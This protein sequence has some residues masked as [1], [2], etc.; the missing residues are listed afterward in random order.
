[1]GT[2]RSEPIRV[3]LERGKKLT[4]AVALDWPGWARS[5]KGD[6]AALETLEAYASRFAPVA[7]AAG[8]PLPEV[9]RLTVVEEVAGSGTTDF[10]APGTA[11]A[12]DAEPMAEAEADRAVALL[13]AA[14]AY[15][16][17]VVAAAP[18]EL[19]KGPR[20]G[21]RDRDKIVEHVVGA[22]IEYARKLGLPR[23]KVAAGDSAA[24][25]VLRGEIVAGLLALAASPRPGLWPPR[26]GGRR[27]AWHA[28]DHAWEM[29]DRR[30]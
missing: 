16:A 27:I 4:F 24:V 11:F 1:M 21:G 20:G 25:E 19:R 17:E 28:L 30:E 8:H 26:Y 15:L 23:H 10:G 3:G 13:E 9:R 18:A 6:E 7:A 22:E 5:G 29:Q 14:W 12:A 2:A